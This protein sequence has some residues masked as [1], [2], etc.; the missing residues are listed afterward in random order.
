MKMKMRSVIAFLLYFFFSLEFK[1]GKKNSLI[2]RKENGV[3]G[4]KE[5]EMLIF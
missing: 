5:E 1:I 3:E 4:K 2:E